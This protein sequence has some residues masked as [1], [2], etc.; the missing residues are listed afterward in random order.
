M[1]T[2]ENW[3]I[4]Q[5]ELND[6]E[7]WGNR[8]GMEFKVMGCKVVHLGNNEKYLLGTEVSSVR[9]DREKIIITGSHKIAK[10][11]KCALT[12]Q[13]ENAI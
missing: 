6:L 13:K 9:N 12:R 10:N 8:N 2:E 11:Y 3:N 5:E 1:N 7:D 4:I